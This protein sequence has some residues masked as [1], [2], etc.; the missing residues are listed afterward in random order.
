MST[1]GTDPGPQAIGT[2]P[3]ELLRPAASRPLED[4]PRVARRQARLAMRLSRAGTGL[5][6]VFA[7]LAELIGDEVTEPAAADVLWRASGLRRPG[8]IAQLGWPRLATRVGLGIE[9]ALAHAI[10]DRMLGFERTGPEQ[11]LQV[12][13]VEWG[14]LGFVVA[15]LLD[16]LA[17]RPGALGPW[18]LYVD[19]VG[20]ELFNIT[21]L[22]PIATIAWPL[23]VGP[24]AGAARLWVPESLVALLLVDEPLPPPLTPGFD[25]AHPDLASSWRAVAGT[26]RLE[27]GPNA[28]EPGAVLRIDGDRLHGTAETPEGPIALTLDA[29]GERWSIAASSVTRSGAGRLRLMGPITREPRP[30]EPGPMP[31]LPDPTAAEPVDLPVTLVVELGRAS[32][33]LSRL[34]DLRPGDLVELNRHP[35]DPVELTSDGRPVA[36]GELVEVDGTLGVRVTKIF[37]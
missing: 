17:G 11:R 15:R 6:P 37:L 2:D 30:P 8:A 7:A 33:P 22:G 31:D 19:R 13:P 5:R 35:R 34:A 21:G 25:V 28:L 18:D 10:V 4:L 26:V 16:R 23:R 36:R 12:T 3:G 29:P 1:D 9:P 20:P 27:A 14:V 24:A 32:L